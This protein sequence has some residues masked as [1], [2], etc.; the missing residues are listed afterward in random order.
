MKK[1]FIIKPAQVI[2]N[3]LTPATKL[4]SSKLLNL[5][6]DSTPCCGGFYTDFTSLANAKPVFSL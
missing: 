1:Q 2:K 4:E 6:A 3:A 5:T